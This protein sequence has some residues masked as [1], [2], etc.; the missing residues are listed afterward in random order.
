MTELSTRGQISRRWTGFDS[1]IEKCLFVLLGFMPLAFGVQSARAKLLVVGLSG[2]M[3]VILM[4]KL[5]VYPQQRLVWSWAYLPVALFVGLVFF[6]LI[7]LPAGI[8]DAISPN[9]SRLR[10]ELL[11]DLPTNANTSDKFALSLYSYAT[12]HDLRLL[13]SAFAVFVVV[14]N[15]YVHPHQ[16]KRLLRAIMLIG[17]LVALIALA[18]DIYDNGRIYWH[19]KSP[20]P[21]AK[22]NSGPFVNHNHFGQFM[23]L[24]IGATLAWLCV[25]LHEDFGRKR[26]GLHSLYDYLSSRSARA[27]W[28]AVGII[29][30]AAATVFVS[31]TRGG[32]VG[33]LTATA[34]TAL[35]LIRRPSAKGYGWI[36]VCAA[37]VAFMFVL[38]LGFDAVWDRL[39]TLRDMEGYKYRWQAI[40]DLKPLYEQFPFF[41]VGLGTHAV[42]YPMFKTIESPLLFTHIENEYAQ[43]LEETGLVGLVLLVL[44]GLFLLS[45]FIK[46]LRTR[47]TPICSAVYG[48]GFGLVAILVH[49]L[50]DYG[51]HVPAN[52]LLSVV[53]CGLLLSLSRQR[54]KVAPREFP[55][56]SRLRRT[57][58]LVATCTV[59]GWAIL[60]GNN[61]RV[62]EAGWHKALDYEKSIKEADWQAS[63]RKYSKLIAAA[64][65]SAAR[66]PGNIRYRYWLNVYRWNAISQSSESIENQVLDLTA[67]KQLRRPKEIIK[68]FY[69]VC[70]LCPTYGPAYAMAG[71]IELFYLGDPS[72]AKRIRRG[73]KLAS[74]DPAVCLAAGRL[75]IVEGRLDA[76]VKPLE[77]AVTLDLSLFKEVTDIYIHQLSRPRLAL[78]AA[79]KDV[80]RLAH[81]ERALEQMQYEDIAEE[82][83]FK[84]KQVLIAKCKGPQPRAH[85]WARLAAVYLDEAD[86]RAAE[87]CYRQALSRDYS[88]VHWRLQLAKVLVQMD[89][90]SDAMYEAKICL[91][92]RPQFKA[93]RAFV[94]ELAVHPAILEKETRTY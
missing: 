61:A 52:G 76:S 75:A 74:D 22:A 62:A 8:A 91:Q 65:R 71:Q 89:R 29:A 47:N 82:T 79:G 81:V 10:D 30:L 15:I 92:I 49:S 73:Y 55:L 9:T 68:Q 18:Q 12:K 66:E 24:S 48:L 21:H 56:G 31:L 19:F 85:D 50:S 17:G 70:Q 5:V 59:W 2:L 67:Y 46:T 88:Q 4:I 80:G 57:V 11:A 83:R 93:A 32:V 35:L 34:V 64:D 77:R 45:A 13:L 39:A 25:K 42:V 72:G 26:M 3:L 6:Q 23:N 43:V 14:S 37:V 69:K 33:M 87:R 63:L 1:A 53:F 60:G 78:T 44:L 41:G 36:I 38:Y 90:I 28:L 58:A 86:Y 51:Q 16:I 94:S 20:H 40:K 27:V 54:H 7:E 84:M